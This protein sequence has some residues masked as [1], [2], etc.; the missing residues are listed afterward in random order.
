MTENNI[1][2]RSNVYVIKKSFKGREGDTNFFRHVHDYYA[3]KKLLDHL[4]GEMNT[5]YYIFT[6]SQQQ[7]VSPEL[8]TGL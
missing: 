7:T 4:H 3:L 1:N 8:D 5:A 6:Y 2:I